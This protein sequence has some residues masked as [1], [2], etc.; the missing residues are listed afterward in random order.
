MKIYTELSGFGHYGVWSI[1]PYP[2]LEEFLKSA[3]RFPDWESPDF[4]SRGIGR[5]GIDYSLIHYRY[6]DKPGIRLGW[7]PHKLGDAMRSLALLA[8]FIPPSPLSESFSEPM[9][10]LEACSFTNGW[11]VKA[12][13]DDPI[14]DVIESPQFAELLPRI[15]RD[16]KLW[17]QDHSNTDMYGQ[18]C[19]VFTGVDGPTLQVYHP[20][21]SGLWIV[22][23]RKKSHGSFQ[24]SD[25]N[26]DS[27]SDAFSHV[28]A[29]CIILKYCREH[30]Q[31]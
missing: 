17:W 4:L 6:N 12:N 27:S 3:D 16:I 15:N 5:T 25:H 22:G 20:G 8:R 18:L 26:T 13:F 24:I 23:T 7:L 28:Y 10:E 19:T 21:S 2:I 1:V 31:A 9:L 14:W 30:L 11:Y 29:L